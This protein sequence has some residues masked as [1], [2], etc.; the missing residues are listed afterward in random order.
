MRRSPRCRGFT[1][2]EL[3]LVVTII[4]ILIALLQPALIRMRDSAR[5]VE[6]KAR[7]DAISRA[8]R[9]FA[10][11][12][13]Q[14]LPAA[15]TGGW[16]GTEPWQL[17]WIGKEG[18]VPGRYEPTHDGVA[19]WYLGGAGAA[20]FYRC[21]AMTAGVIGTG[22]GSNGSF[23]YAMT[24]SF[25]GARIRSIP[26]TS[27]VIYQ[28]DHFGVDEGPLPTPLVIDEDPAYHNNSISIEPGFGS[29]D[30]SP[31][32]HPYRSANYAAMDGSI[33][34]LAVPDDRRAP[35][36]W[37]WFCIAPHG[38]LVRLNGGVLYRGWRNQ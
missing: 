6:C 16:Q 17:C 33:K 36:A 7:L 4:L 18:R 26:L 29:I 11:D 9:L 38:S 27:R 13:N 8:F 25:S 20:G 12:N 21:P 22:V 1:L 28:T 3:L 14:M 15:S 35:Q 5:D 30:R 19:S 32:R 37:E 2:V 31:I 23:D 10:T 24:L 34:N